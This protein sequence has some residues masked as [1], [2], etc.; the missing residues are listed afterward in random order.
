M[1][2]PT[3]R[4]EKCSYLKDHFAPVD[5]QQNDALFRH[6]LDDPTDRLLDEGQLENLKTVAAAHGWKVEVVE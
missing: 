5:E 6:L 1:N 4:V 2:T 3:I